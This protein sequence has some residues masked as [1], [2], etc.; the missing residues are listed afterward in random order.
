M[1][2][3]SS[4]RAEARKSLE[5][6]W[7]D[8]AVAS[9]VIGMIAMLLVTPYV[10][11]QSVFKDN[12]VVQSINLLY[13]WLMLLFFT[14]PMSYAFMNAFMPLHR[15]TFNNSTII[16]Q[17]LSVFKKSYRRA[18]FSAAFVILAIFGLV[19]AAIIMAL[20]FTVIILV[21][22]YGSEAAWVLGTED[23]IVIGMLLMFGLM[24]VCMIPLYIYTYAIV[25]YPFVVED[26][27]ELDERECLKKCRQMMRG[28]K[29]KLFC[30]NLS[31]I[32]WVLLAVLT[33]GIGMLWLMPYIQASCAAFYDDLRREQAGETA[34]ETEVTDVT[35][36]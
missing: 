33:C 9:L 1:K 16:E 12:V 31:F 5:G 23:G 2:S 22:K 29:W 6:R 20:I 26:N 25:L 8:A 18:F 19:F 15:G 34:A 35:E 27:P 28:Y 30:L 14:L 36:L 21:A 10:I 24:I 7:A 3:L 11:M 17:V 13:Y 4:Y 32:G